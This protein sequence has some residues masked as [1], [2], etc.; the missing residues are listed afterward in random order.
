MA[1]R[2]ISCKIKIRNTISKS[3]VNRDLSYRIR[4]PYKSKD[5]YHND[6]SFLSC[7]NDN[8]RIIDT[9]EY[10]YISMY[11]CKQTITIETTS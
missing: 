6:T 4:K 5:F 2:Y 11:C 7:K 1:R 10:E 8:T 9:S 3:V